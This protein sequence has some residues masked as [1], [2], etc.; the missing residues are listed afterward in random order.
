MHVENKKKAEKSNGSVFPFQ[1][2]FYF[3]FANTVVQ[4]LNEN[5]VRLPELKGRLFPCHASTRRQIS[6]PGWGRGW[7]QGSPASEKW[8]LQAGFPP[9]PL[10]PNSHKAQLPC[11]NSSSDETSSTFPVQKEEAQAEKQG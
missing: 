9:L 8:Q 11:G 3:V 5:A 4:H 1:V 10:P 7:V 6:L 2:N